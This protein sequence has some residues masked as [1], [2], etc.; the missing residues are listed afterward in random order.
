LCAADTRCFFAGVKPV[1]D[2]DGH[3]TRFTLVEFGVSGKRLESN[4]GDSHGTGPMDPKEDI[5]PF[6]AFAMQ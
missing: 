1:P 5:G 4:L 6:H 2:A 3:I